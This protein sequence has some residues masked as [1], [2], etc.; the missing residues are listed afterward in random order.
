MRRLAIAAPSLLLALVACS[1]DFGLEGIEAGNT[2]PDTGTPAVEEEEPEEEPEEE[3]TPPEEEEE[4]PPEDDCTETDERIY[5]VERDDKTVYL[6]DPTTLSF[7]SLGRLS[8]L[9][10]AS[11]G[12]MA[13]GR[14]GVAWVRSSSDELF[15]VSLTDLSCDRT[16]FR[17]PAG[18]D[19]FGMGFATEYSGTWRDH[20]YVADA[21]SLGVLDTADLSVDRLGSMASQSE[22]TGNALGELWAFL[23]LLSPARLV[24]ID[25]GSGAELERISLPSFPPASEIDAFAFATW[26]GDFWLFVRSYG[27]GNSTDVYRVTAAGTM[28]LELRDVGFD[29]VGAGVSTCAPTE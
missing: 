26:G 18:F 10:G 4:P 2:A 24:Q 13:V 28:T 12:S 21:D 14:D 19:S 27:M 9:G 1:P 3:T 25:Q 20:L 5:V 29:V 11:P 8:C 22:L 7:E 16:D 23:P 17:L 15:Q 6:F